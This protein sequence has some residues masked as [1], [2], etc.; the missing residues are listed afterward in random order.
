MPPKILLASR[1]P[2]EF[3]PTARAAARLADETG[4]DLLLAYVAIELSTV[5]QV[6]AA[7]GEDAE[8]LRERMI[9]GGRQQAAEYLRRNLP[10]R[11]VQIW[12]L[13]GSVVEAICDFARQERVDYLVIG[14]EGR[15]RLSEVFLGSTSQE[16]LRQAPCPVV[17]V[18]PQVHEQ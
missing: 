6:R 5:Q 11:E 18:P 14:T 3:D 16:L 17:V 2:E 7:T 15:S 4:G 13:E 10:G 8:G 12:I 1:L 9:E